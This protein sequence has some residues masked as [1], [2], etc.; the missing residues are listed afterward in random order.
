VLIYLAKAEAF[1]LAAKCVGPMDVSPAVWREAAE[2]WAEMDAVEVARMRV[3]AHDG[4]LHRVE[5][6]EQT[7]RRAGDLAA[8]HRLG[9]GE[10]EV[11]ALAHVGDCVILDED[12]AT[13][14]AKSMG[15]SP[16]RTLRIPVLGAAR[17]TLSRTAAMEMLQR[18]ALVSS[19]PSDLVKELEHLLGRY[20][21]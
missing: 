19:A 20:S 12:R 18:L 14:V 3:A 15:L 1:V 7:R 10:S 21:R 8:G 13:A 2:A 11:L 5:L 4:I 17:G 6:S 16:I 9:A